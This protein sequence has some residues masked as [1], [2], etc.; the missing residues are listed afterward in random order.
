MDYIKYKKLKKIIDTF[1]N[2][3][4]YLQQLLRKKYHFKHDTKNIMQKDE[5]LDEFSGKNLRIDNNQSGGVRG[6]CTTS[7]L[8]DNRTNNSLKY[9]YTHTL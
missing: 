9:I 8:G 7:F 2:M 1:K 4:H 6:K 5:S 3:G